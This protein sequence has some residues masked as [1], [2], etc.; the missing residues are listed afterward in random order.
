MLKEDGYEAHLPDKFVEG[1]ICMLCRNLMAHPTLREGIAKRFDDNDL[2]EAVA[3]G[4]AHYLKEPE[5]VQRL[6]IA[7][8]SQREIL[9][10]NLNAPPRG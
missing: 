7:A 5:M 2:V 10:G 6:G 4:R 8:L 3:Y 9:S 1:N